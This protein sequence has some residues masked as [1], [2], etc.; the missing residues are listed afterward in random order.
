MV[1]APPPDHSVVGRRTRRRG[2][3][4]V[5]AA[6]AGQPAVRSRRGR[7]AI[8]PR[9]RAAPR[10]RTALGCSPWSAGQPHGPLPPYPPT[11]KAGRARCYAARVSWSAAGRPSAAAARMRASARKL[12]ST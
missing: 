7:Q 6:R 9:R 1:L 10:V 2:W 3:R 5:V 11:K 8:M 12:I 4:A